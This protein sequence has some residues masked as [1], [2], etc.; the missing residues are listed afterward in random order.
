VRNN[1]LW[2]SKSFPG[3]E[4]WITIPTTTPD[5]GDVT[6]HPFPGEVDHFV[7]CILNK[8]KTIVDLDDAIKTFELIEAADRSARQSG[9]PVSLPL[10]W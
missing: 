3:Q 5:S 7:E 9:K 8:K 1:A 2:A 10:G 6:H 4:G